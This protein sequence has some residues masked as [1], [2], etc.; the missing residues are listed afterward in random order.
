MLIVTF[1]EILH[2]FKAGEQPDCLLLLS[3]DS[4]SLKIAVAW[5]GISIRRVELGKPSP[6]E[7]DAL[8]WDWLWSSVSYS[9]AEVAVRTGLTTYLIERKL[10]GLVANRVI[11]PDGT[12]NS[13]VQR[14]LRE[15]VLRLFRPAKQRERDA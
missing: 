7:P 4:A 12:L 10:P 9:I 14:Y 8:R 11:Y 5:G 15:R 13:F 2:Q 1:D 3:E 6:D